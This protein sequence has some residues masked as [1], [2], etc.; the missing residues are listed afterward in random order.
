MPETAIRVYIFTRHNGLSLRLML[1]FSLEHMKPRKGRLQIWRD[2]A[3]RTTSTRTPS[4]L[5]EVLP[6]WSHST[7]TPPLVLHCS[8]T[9]TIG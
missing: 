7:V 8:W 6:E 1:N 4:S 2:M 3:I 9:L 5:P